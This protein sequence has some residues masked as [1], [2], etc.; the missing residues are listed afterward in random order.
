MATVKGTGPTDEQLELARTL[1]DRAGAANGDAKSE[2]GL[3]VMSTRAVAFPV[4]FREPWMG[5]GNGPVLVV[6][7]AGEFTTDAG[8][9]PPQA[10]ANGPEQNS[11]LVLF[12][13]PV[14]QSAEDVYVGSTPVDLS[15]LGT[16]VPLP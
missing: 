1:I 6:S 9:Q 8:D 13:N 7:I 4:V 12:V 16:Q 11:A 5:A 2:P 15:P 3:V 14:S 10:S